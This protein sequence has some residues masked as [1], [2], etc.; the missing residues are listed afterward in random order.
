MNVLSE[1]ELEEELKKERSFI[2]ISTPFCGTCQV[3]EKIL[4]VVEKMMP[5][6][7]LR[8]INANYFPKN[9]EKWQVESVPCLLVLEQGR[10]KE[11]VYAFHS[12]PFMYEFF[13]RYM[14]K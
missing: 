1:S 3:A 13:K 6:L 7:E 10:I 9:M 5:K 2:Y 8:T 4:Q 14:S 12:V 11:K